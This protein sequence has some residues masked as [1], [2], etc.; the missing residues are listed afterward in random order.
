MDLIDLEDESID[1]EVMKSPAV[2]M[3]NLRVLATLSVVHNINYV[4]AHYVNR[5][6]TTLFTRVGGQMCEVYILTKNSS[7]PD[8]SRVD[9]CVWGRGDYNA[10]VLPYQDRHN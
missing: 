3:D 9:H 7:L 8:Y 5:L 2:S 1:A 6:Y 10:C 4:H